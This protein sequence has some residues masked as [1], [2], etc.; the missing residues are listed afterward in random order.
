MKN[1]G[2]LLKNIEIFLKNIGT[3]LKNIGIFFEK[4]WHIIWTQ[5]SWISSP[6]LSC[7]FQNTLEYCKAFEKHWNIFEKHWNIF[8]KHW[9]IFWKKLEFF[10]K[11][12]EKVW[13]PHYKSHWKKHWVSKIRQDITNFPSLNKVHVSPACWSQLQTEMYVLFKAKMYKNQQKIQ[14]DV[15]S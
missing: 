14:K 1:I 8:E 9:N 7:L 3:Y 15:W 10:W 4:N 13:L 5:S 12:L 6:K 2:K 11:K